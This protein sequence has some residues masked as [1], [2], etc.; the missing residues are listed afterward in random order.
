MELGGTR[1]PDL[2]GAIQALTVG[3]EDNSQRPG[4]CPSSGHDRS[5]LVHGVGEPERLLSPRE[6]AERTGLSYHAVL[7]AIHRGELPAFRLC[8]RIR[9][10][11]SDVEAWM[12]DHRI[13]QQGES[14]PRSPLLGV[15]ARPLRG[16]LAALRALEPDEKR[17]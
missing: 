14:S 6:V 8:G 13:E 4:R 7:R 17:T 1:T 16:S 10:R 2:L 15:G 3:G 9:I 12:R 5:P 11:P